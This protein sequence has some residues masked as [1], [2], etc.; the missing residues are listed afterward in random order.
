MYRISAVF[1]PFVRKGIL[2]R[3]LLQYSEELRMQLPLPHLEGKYCVVL[4]L[5]C[6]DT[7]NPLQ[8]GRGIPIH[9]TITSCTPSSFALA[10]AGP[11]CPVRG[12]S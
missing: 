6:W 3:R 9:R 7:M 12:A 2:V 8:Q 5:V 4:P 11:C 1:P 10:R